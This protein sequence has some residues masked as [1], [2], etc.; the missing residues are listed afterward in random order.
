[1]RSALGD[2]GPAFRL[3]EDQAVLGCSLPPLFL[4]N[5]ELEMDRRPS[6]PI[7]TLHGTDDGALRKLMHLLIRGADERRGCDGLGIESLFVELGTRLLFASRLLPQ[8]SPPADSHFPRHLLRR[9]LERMHEQL[10]SNL[11]L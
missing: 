6:G 1:M 5:L 4:H 8:K 11:S 7:Q 10:D 2:N 9:V 3:K